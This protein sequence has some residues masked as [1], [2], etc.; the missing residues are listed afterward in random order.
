MGGPQHH[1]GPPQGY[2]NVP[3]PQH[4][5]NMPPHQQPPQGYNNGCITIILTADF[6]NGIDFFCSLI[7][8]GNGS[9]G[10]PPGPGSF[11]GESESSA[12]EE[13][14]VET[15][16]ADGK[17]YF[18]HAKTRET[19]WTKPEGPNVKVLT[20]QQVTIHVEPLVSNVLSNSFSVA[21]RGYGPATNCRQ[22]TGSR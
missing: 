14:W 6:W 10:G 20:Q 1:Q 8:A 17:S 11:Q 7:I 13:V 18:Y 12:N 3:P 9:Y 21:G 15:K 16:T 4:Y 5:G 2:G 19:T 22:A